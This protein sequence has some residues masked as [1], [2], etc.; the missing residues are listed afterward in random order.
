[1]S[2]PNEINE[3][4]VLTIFPMSVICNSTNPSSS[5]DS[6]GVAS[7]IITGGTPPYT[8][9]WENGNFTQTITNLSVGSYTVTVTDYYGDN[10]ITTTCVLSFVE[11]PTPTPTPT[12]TPEPEII[13]FCLVFTP[14]DYFY[15]RS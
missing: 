8:I 6:D 14:W 13:D 10:V 2:V 5:E 11:P 15:N 9:E 7:I 4:G 12:P 3:C 1:M